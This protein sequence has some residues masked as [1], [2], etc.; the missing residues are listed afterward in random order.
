MN[1]IDTLFEEKVKQV[2]ERIQQETELKQRAQKEEDLRRRQ[3]V[4][5]IPLAI[6]RVQRMF[7]KTVSEKSTLTDFICKIVISRICL[8]FTRTDYIK[9]G[10]KSADKV[11]GT[12]VMS[13]KM[14]PVESCFAIVPICEI[15]SL[16]TEGAQHSCGTSFV[17]A[18]DIPAGPLWDKPEV[19][20]VK[21]VCGRLSSTHGSR[22]F[23]EGHHI[24]SEDLLDK[25]EDLRNPEIFIKE[26][27]ESYPSL[28]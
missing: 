21:I 17:I 28:L 2:K 23:T 7:S 11:L 16:G 13:Q 25:L 18:L 12:N 27:L 14:R 10:K 24:P 6:K 5:S 19:K 4:E 15:K 1:E 20:K 8:L 26:I 9:V 3:I 22:D